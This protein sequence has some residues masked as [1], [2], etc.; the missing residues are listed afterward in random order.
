M[1]GHRLTAS[2]EDC[3]G[4]IIDTGPSVNSP[5]HRRSRVNYQAFNGD[6][7]GRLMHV[8]CQVLDN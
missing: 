1:V 6:A 7:V 3:V 4:A 5:V 8:Q 2:T